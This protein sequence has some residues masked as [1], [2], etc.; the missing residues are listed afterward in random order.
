MSLNMGMSVWL[1]MALEGAY[2]AV[3]IIFGVLSF[4]VFLE[5]GVLTVFHAYISFYLYKRTVEI[6]AP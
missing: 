1:G 6:L 4:A 2:R 3:S 5:I